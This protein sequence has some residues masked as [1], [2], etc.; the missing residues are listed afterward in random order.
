MKNHELLYY[1]TVLQ[2][3]DPPAP[4]K[5]FGLVDFK[6]EKNDIGMFT[7]LYPFVSEAIDRAERALQKQI[8]EHGD[9]I[10][11]MCPATY[12]HRLVRDLLAYLHKGQR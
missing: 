8:A 11:A 3:S 6:Y 9:D 4:R 12:V 1:S 7:L 5:R 2:G 10:A